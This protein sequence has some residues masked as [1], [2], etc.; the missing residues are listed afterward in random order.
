MLSGGI[1]D[2]RVMVRI[3]IAKGPEGR[4]SSVACSGHAEFSD[5]EHGGDIVCA[6]VSALTGYLGLT[7]SEVLGFPQ[8][9]GA[10][11]GW[12]FFRR[13]SDLDLAGQAVLDTLL[14][15]WVRSVRALEEN[16]SG[17]V[18]VEQTL[19]GEIPLAFAGEDDEASRS[20]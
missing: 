18:K 7:V 17:W 13:P 5:E 19:A 8:A 16:Y 6:A 14:E 9:V 1:S 11:D 10:E 15:G 12:F 4:W 3:V 2:W 20:H